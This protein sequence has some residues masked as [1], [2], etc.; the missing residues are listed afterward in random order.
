MTSPDPDLNSDA[1]D[2]F[3]RHMR[4][5][6]QCMSFYPMS[7]MQLKIDALRNAFSANIRK[8][9]VL[10]PSFVHGS[11]ASGVSTSPDDINN[12]QLM[13]HNSGS[14][15]SASSGHGM[16]QH[17][18]GIRGQTQNI[19]YISHPQTNSLSVS[20]PTSSKV[21]LALGICPRPVHVQNV[22]RGDAPIQIMD[23]IRSSE[24]SG[25]ILGDIGEVEVAQ[26]SLSVMMDAV[27]W[28]PSRIF[29]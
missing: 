6:E 11:L 28:D 2:Y 17:G 27:T 23:G 13:V 19:S 15:R 29:E 26:G 18:Q 3:T 25:P 8:P 5:L 12:L 7:E 9:F 14:S 1:R 24:S 20:L 16:L 10:N 4:I 21:S 22:Q